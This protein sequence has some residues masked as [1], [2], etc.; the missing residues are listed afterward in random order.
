[1]HFREGIPIVMPAS[2]AGGLIRVAHPRM[3]S[4]LTAPGHSNGL[5]KGTVVGSAAKTMSGHCN[6]DQQFIIRPIS[7]TFQTELIMLFLQ[8][9]RLRINASCHLSLFDVIDPSVKFWQCRNGESVTN[10]PNIA[11]PF[12][13][14]NTSADHAHWAALE[15]IKNEVEIPSA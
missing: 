12:T 3:I 5:L 9:A 14:T 11:E 1:M 4:T 8:F 6:S 15:S 10:G 13:L 7:E 2:G